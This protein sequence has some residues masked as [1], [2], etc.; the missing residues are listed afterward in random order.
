M[1]GRAAYGRPW[2][3]RQI[4]EYFKTGTESA[5][6]TPRELSD[7]VLE[8]YDAI[9]DYYGH[10]AGVGVARKHIGWY[11]KDM[12]GSDDLRAGINKMTDPEL[13]K[14]ALSDYFTR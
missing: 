3:V 14:T 5:A 2:I 6:P 10:H 4:I 12:E 11:C 1:V 13:V 8:H 7:L 9:L